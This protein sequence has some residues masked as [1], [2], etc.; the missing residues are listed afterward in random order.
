MLKDYYLY[1]DESGNLGKNGKYFIISCILT[2]APKALQNKMKKTLLFI[3]KQYPH[4]KFNDYEL[5]AN[6]ANSLSRTTILSNIADKDL[7]ISYIVADKDHVYNYLLDDKNLFYNY[8]LKILLNNFTSLFR[9]ASTE[10][11]TIHLI[12][13]NRSIKVKSKNS[14]ADFIKIYF[15]YEKHINVNIEVEYRD[16]KASNAYNVQAADYVAHALYSHYEYNNS[17]YF[18][19]F[20]SKIKYEELFPRCKFGQSVKNPEIAVSVD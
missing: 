18:N 10:N 5:K 8:L 15:L 11:A 13:D 12:L 2:S 19:C 4:L 20:K 1:F 16:S 9:K 17:N 6:A 7:S 14:F 3:K